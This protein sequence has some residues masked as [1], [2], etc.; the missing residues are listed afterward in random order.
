M[1][2]NFRLRKKKTDTQG[3]IRL[4]LHIKEKDLEDLLELKLSIT[5]GIKKQRLNRVQPML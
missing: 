1:N 4:D 5:I 2:V 3:N